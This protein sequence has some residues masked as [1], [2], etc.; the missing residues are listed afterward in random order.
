MFL[1]N[2]CSSRY[3]SDIMGHQ[4]N[5]QIYPNNF[6]VAEKED[7]DQA[8]L[9]P[10]VRSQ[11]SSEHGRSE[12]I[13]ISYHILKAP[14]PIYNKASQEIPHCCP[15]AELVNSMAV[16]DGTE[17]NKPIKDVLSSEDRA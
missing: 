2:T 14:A 3:P 6:Q 1:S 5:A 11:N 4:K 15:A 13:R 10:R 17:D 16:Q 12:R 7:L 8:G 9:A